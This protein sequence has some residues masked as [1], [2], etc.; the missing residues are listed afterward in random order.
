MGIGLEKI[1]E[2]FLFEDKYFVK[3]IVKIKLYTYHNQWMNNSFYYFF[4]HFHNKNVSKF[5][6]PVEEE[7][8]DMVF[9]IILNHFNKNI[10]YAKKM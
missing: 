3:K 6:S 8:K 5:Y 2:C 4:A 10:D 7:W 9:L 1:L